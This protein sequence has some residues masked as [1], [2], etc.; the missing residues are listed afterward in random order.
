ME[1][2][3]SIHRPLKLSPRT[4]MRVAAEAGVCTMTVRRFEAGTRMDIRT[5]LAVVAALETLGVLHGT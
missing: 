4:R 2:A 1:L 5:E 3:T